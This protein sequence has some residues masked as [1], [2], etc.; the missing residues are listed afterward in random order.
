MRA[1]FRWWGDLPDSVQSEKVR[2]L[3]A[4][5]PM[6]VVAVVLSVAMLC[7]VEWRS[8]KPLLLGWMGCALAVAGYRLTIHRAYWRARPADAHWR[9][10]LHLYWAGALM[11]ACC[12]GSTAILFFE[13]R[14]PLH[15]AFLAYIV[16]GMALGGAG[17]FAAFAGVSHTYSIVTIGP[18]IVRFME[19]G[20]TT[21]IAMGVLAIMFLVTLLVIS[22]RVRT[23]IDAAQRLRI[24]KQHL[25]EDLERQKGA[26]DELNTNLQTRVEEKTAEIQR[27]LDQKD[28]FIGQLGHDLK[29]PLTPLVAML[30]LV[31]RRASDPRQREILQLLSDNVEYL[32]NLVDKVLQLAR[33]TGSEYTLDLAPVDLRAVAEDIVRSRDV[34]LAETQLAIT[35]GVTERV[36]VQADAFFVREVIDN[37]VT[38]A[39]RYSGEQGTIT[40][41][42]CAVDDDTVM[43][44]VSDEGEGIAADQLPL[45]FD[46][47]YKVDQSRHD[48]N[49]AGLG[50]AICKRIVEKHGGEIWA[51]SAG[52]GSGA[53]FRFTLT[54]ETEDDH[55]GSGR[56]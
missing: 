7:I 9:P 56:R 16:G 30:P 41:D 46:E 45:I 39:V 32:R 35:S 34:V 53:T 55:V 23:F 3:Y 40:I 19:L 49:S 25:A 51:E 29:T 4:Q 31:A 44:S 17:A 24:E 36:W 12:W 20:H 14:D 26:V 22:C 5:T 42:A 1:C 11:S 13:P 33:C 37:L 38:N 48:H 47:F 21:G 6:L 28:Q 10:W 52:L 15:Q 50:L 43:I 8:P 27:L 54:R 18:M 2:L